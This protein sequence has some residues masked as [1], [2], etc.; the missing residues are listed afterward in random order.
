MI[1]YLILHPEFRNLEHVPSKFVCSVISNKNA[2]QRNEII[3]K[4][5]E[6]GVTIDKEKVPG[7]YWDQPLLNYY[8]GYKFVLAFENTVDDYYITEKVINVLKAGVIPIYFG[9]EKINLFINKDRI[10]QINESNITTIISRM[11]YLH[12]KPHEWLKIVKEKLFTE[13]IFNFL[14]NVVAETRLFLY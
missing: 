7:G 1:P 8:S 5:G 11:K 6:Y 3:R 13:R 9:S 10:F 2:S 14:N 4:M 12:E